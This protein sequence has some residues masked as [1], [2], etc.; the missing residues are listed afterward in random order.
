MLRHRAIPRHR[1]ITGRGK[2][3]DWFRKL[4]ST[5]KSKQLISKGLAAVAPYLGQYQGLAGA[6]GQLAGKMGY[7]RRRRTVGH[8][9]RLAGGMRRRHVRRAYY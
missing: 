2:V 9:L 1:R 3:A 8:G 7:G 4:G 6:A 5:I